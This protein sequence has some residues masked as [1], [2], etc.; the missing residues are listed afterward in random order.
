M[1]AKQ[2]AFHY[3]SLVQ[4]MQLDLAL[5]VHLRVFFCS[6]SCELVTGR[7][8][9]LQLG[10]S[11]RRRHVHLRTKKG[12]LELSKVLPH[13]NLAE[14]LTKNLTPSG[15]HRLLPK[16]SV[17]TRAVDSQAWLTRLSQ[18]QLA[19]F[20]GSSFFIGMVTLHPQMALTKASSTVLSLQLSS[21]TGGGEEKEKDIA[22]PQLATAQLQ[23]RIVSRKSLQCQK[24]TQ[25]SFDSLTRYSLSRLN[26]QK[27]NQ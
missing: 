27:Y 4:G 2:L 1:L 8:L 26:Q 17:H 14:S 22:Y 21:L 25:I 9:A 11:R 10:L 5:L 19:S 15:L 24:L 6:L 16:L 13:K 18:E 12:Q 3:Q 20:S 7:P 23:Q